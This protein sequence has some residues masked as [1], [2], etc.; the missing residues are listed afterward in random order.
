MS[1]PAEALPASAVIHR[2][3]AYISGGHPRQV[4]DL[5]LPSESG[6]APLLVWVHGGAFRMGSKEDHVPF[7]M[8]HQGYAIAALNYRLR[9]IARP[10]AL[11][12]LGRVGGRSSSGDVGHSRSRAQLRGR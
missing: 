12:V 11:R 10:N 4:L 1:H 8:L 9:H 5:Y 2:E 6:P 3:L 7:E